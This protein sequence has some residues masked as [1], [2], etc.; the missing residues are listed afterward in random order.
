MERERS[1]FG[2]GG[3]SAY[4]SAGDARRLALGYKFQILDSRFSGQYIIIF[5][6]EDLV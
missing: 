4:K 2:G 1:S 5:S 6:C 3:G